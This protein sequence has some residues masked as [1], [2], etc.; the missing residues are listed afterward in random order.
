MN[1]MRFLLPVLVCGGIVSAQSS[2][3]GNSN[4]NA[5]DP[6]PEPVAIM[7]APSLSDDK[8]IMGVVPNYATVNEPEKTYTFKPL[9]VGQ[10]FMTATH[11]SFDPFNWVVP[12]AY[13]GVYQKENEYSGFGQGAAGYFKRYGALFADATIST[14]IS[15]AIMP[16]MLHE[17][18]RYFRLGSGTKM[19]RIFY[20]MTRVLVTKTDYD[21]WRFNNSEIWG[22]LV[23][24]GISN[25]YYPAA[26][27]T[28]GNT[29]EKFG[30]GV[31]SDS[32]FNVLKEFWPDMKHR[33]LHRD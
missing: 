18:P 3:E 15:E 28:V 16:V 22:N 31:V 14:Y 9:T 24:A 5:A 29:F 17:D 20:A 13:A 26:N 25:L 12:L 27:R 19:H 4:A 10:K 11:D 7:K 23:A 32:A 21:T 2:T 33:V 6:S 1:V 8:H 30:V